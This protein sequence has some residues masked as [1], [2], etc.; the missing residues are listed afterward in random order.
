MV[1]DEIV[2][3]PTMTSDIEV[4]LPKGVETAKN[5]PNSKFSLKI[6]GFEKVM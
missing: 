2:N 5:S 6:A 4:V 1:S 3:N